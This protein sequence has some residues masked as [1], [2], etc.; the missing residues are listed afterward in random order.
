MTQLTLLSADGVTT[1]TALAEAP[2]FGRPR[3]PLA[4]RIAYAAAHVVP[5]RWAENVPGAPAD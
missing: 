3:S 5:K 4:S 1:R 2:V